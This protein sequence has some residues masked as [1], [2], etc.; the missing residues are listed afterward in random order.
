[1]YCPNDREQRSASTSSDSMS[2]ADRLLAA[3]DLA[4]IESMDTR[5][6]EVEAVP[7][8]SISFLFQKISSGDS[9][10]DSPVES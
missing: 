1:M 10:K 2:V 5:K 9:G 8:G 4:A 3:V 6:L 7:Q